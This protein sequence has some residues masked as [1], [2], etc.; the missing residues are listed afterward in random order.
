MAFLAIFKCRGNT[1]RKDMPETLDFLNRGINKYQK[2]AAAKVLLNKINGLE[3]D[4]KPHKA[5][6]SNGLLSSLYELYNKIANVSPKDQASR[7]SYSHTYHQK[8]SLDSSQSPKMMKT[9]TIQDSYSN[10]LP[11]LKPRVHRSKSS[12]E[13]PKRKKKEISPS[14]SSIPSEPQKEEI[15]NAPSTAPKPFKIKPY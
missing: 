12:S 5:A 8:K 15:I 6:L 2:I 1:Q 4:L 7:K 3:S 9:D 11:E 10:M 13:S 14:P